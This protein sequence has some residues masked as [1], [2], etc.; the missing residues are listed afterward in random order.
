MIVVSR[1]SHMTHM[2]LK[3]ISMTCF[4][5]SVLI[6]ELQLSEGFK[7]IGYCVLSLPSYLQLY[8]CCAVVAMALSPSTKYASI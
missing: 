7:H 4:D 1:Q 3:D 8:Q 5:D 2:L 6:I